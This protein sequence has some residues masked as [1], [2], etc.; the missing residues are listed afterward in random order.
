LAKYIR[1]P[2]SYSCGPTAIL[3]ALKWAGLDVTLQEFP[4]LQFSCRT[5]D[6]DSNDIEDHGTLDHDFDRV[7]RWSGKKVLKVRRRKNPSFK[8]IY[9]HVKSG[10]AICLGYFW[11]EK[12]QGGEHF[13]FISG[14]RRGLFHVVNDHTILDFSNSNDRLR[15]SKTIKNW[16]KIK[17]DDCPIAWFLTRLDAIPATL[18]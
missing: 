18:K 12:K 6:P 17:T 9:I 11:R 2:D 16:M 8:D 4:L 10:G 1:Q 7:L 5:V 14:M 13:C 3:N 15:T